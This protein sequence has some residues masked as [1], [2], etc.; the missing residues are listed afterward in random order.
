MG[1]GAGEARAPPRHVMPPPLLLPAAGTM[2]PPRALTHHVPAGRGRALKGAAPE[3]SHS[4]LQRRTPTP[5]LPPPPRASTQHTASLNNSHFIP[6]SSIPPNPPPLMTYP[7]QRRARKYAGGGGGGAAPRGSALLLWKRRET[8]MKRTQRG[9]ENHPKSTLT[10][11]KSHLCQRE[12]KAPSVRATPLSVP[13]PHL[14][15]S[16]PHSCPPLPT[17]PSRSVGITQFTFLSKLHSDLKLQVI[18]AKGARL[19]LQPK[20]TQPNTQIKTK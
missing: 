19:S 17:P 8:G 16:S 12:N 14:C 9:K 1:V 5:H 20:K 6:L 15:G 7:Q 4:R 13:S 18:K 10:P 2:A 11:S 3:L